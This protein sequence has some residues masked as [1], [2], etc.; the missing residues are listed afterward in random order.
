MMKRTQFLDARRNIRKEFVAF[1]SIVI[2][3]MLASMAYL[4]VTYSAATLRKDAL[5]FFN[6]NGLWDIEVASTM[7]MD[8]DDLAAIRA[9]PGVKD[10]E[11]VYQAETKL[12]IGS[13]FTNVS[14]I[15]QPEHISV[16]VLCEGHFPETAAECAVEKEL[17]DRQ[18]FSVG[19]QISLDDSD[20]SDIDPLLNKSYVITGIFDSPDHITF[21]VPVTPYILIR[22]ESFNK[23]LLND[24]FMK[25]HIRVEGAPENRYSDEYWETIRPVTEAL[26]ALAAERAPAR[27][28]KLRSVYEERIQDGQNQLDDAAEQIRQARETIDSGYLELEAAAEQ[29]G[30][31]KDRLDAGAGL[32]SHAADLID[33]GAEKL[34]K[35]KQGLEFLRG[36][37]DKGKDWILDNFSEEDWPADVDMTYAEFRQALEDGE[38]VTMDW[39][40]EKS[41]Y[42]K[43]L[44]TLRE[45]MEKFEAGRLDYYYLGEQY[46]DGL[47]R[48]EKGRKQLEQGEEEL[49]EA[50]EQYDAADRLLQEKKK[51]LKQLGDCRWVVMNVHMN[52]GFAYSEEN[53]SKLESLSMSFSSIFLIVGALVIYA[54]VGRMVEQQRKLIG[55]TKALGLYNREIL[56]KYLFFAC[57]AS[58]LGVGL[59]IIFS[60]LPLQRIALQTYEELFTYGTGTRSFLPMET[61]FVVFGAL[62]ISIAAVYLACRQ[63]LRLPAIQLM[64][65][66]ISVGS[67]K[68]TRSSAE[69]RLFT[70][71]IL[72]NIRTDWKRVMVTTVCI[73]GGCM[74]MVIGFTL[75]YGISG[76]N[77]RQFSEVQTYQAEIFYDSSLNA[78]AASEI[79]ATLDGKALP[80]VSV[81]KQSS[82]F[83]ADNSQYTMTMIIADKGSLNGYYSLRDI[84]S[85]E[86]LELPESG[87]LVPRRFREFYRIGIGNSVSVY[88]NDMNLLE[89][90]VAGVF[91]NYYG[92][93]FFLT[94]Q[95]YEDCFGS[96]PEKNCFFVKTKGMPLA[97]LQEML[98]NIKG[99]VSVNDAEAERALI[100]RF[101]AP[102][103]FVVW[104]MLFIAAIMACFIV[105]NFTMT[106]I[107]RKTRELTIMRINGFSTLECIRYIAVDL[108]ITTILGTILGLVLGG[109]VGSRILHVTET[110]FIQMIREPKLLTFLYS[111]LL[112]FCFSLLTNGYALRRVKKLKLSDIT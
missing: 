93:L 2:I 59:G 74:L 111:A 97:E 34:R 21:M 40:C 102:L 15:S 16:P 68:K 96:A 4:V 23:E 54:T 24:A 71:L 86:T 41:G 95:S 106:Y 5:R 90:K 65:G 112:T 80:H 45:A 101:S 89:L 18:G 13:S 11:R 53:A 1:L 92:Q 19:Q 108:L 99:L 110:P 32:L 87:A 39:L 17:A 25:V 82:V 77:D 9:I 56:A 3:G 52:P 8:E 81:Q 78:N 49:S 67:H 38:A 35:A 55:A 10:A 66:V 50:L 105:A 42:N 76:V 51:E 7:L 22:E 63:L 104:F 61:G 29:L 47:T 43:G 72:R 46:L 44:T 100:D 88:D 79:E 6:S 27:T 26:E 37:L 58:L 64:S 107:Q 103:N 31:G 98:S 30:L 62:V 91:E 60:W 48:L 20:V 36:I 75:R 14:V 69:S 84:S 70:R 28:E 73:A 57:S 12:R 94:P 33:S 109:I 83:N 85:G